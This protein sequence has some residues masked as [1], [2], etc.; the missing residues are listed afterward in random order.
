MYPL[1]RGSNSLIKSL[2]D[3]N[4]GPN[5]TKL[6]P[7]TKEIIPGT[8]NS[9]HVYAEL[10]GVVPNMMTARVEEAMHFFG[11]LLKHIGEDRI[12]WG[13]DCLWFASP[14]P[15]IEAFRC[16]EIS[17]KFQEKYGYPALTQERKS[18][19]FGQNSARLQTVRGIDTYVGK[20]HADI[21]GEMAMRHKRE[22][23]EE[24]GRRRDMIDRVWGPRTR[25]EFLAL[26][27]QEEREK[28]FWSG[29]IPHRS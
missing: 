17:T 3:A 24:F 4:I 19:I 8:E 7:K 1:D 16:F 20:C 25:R 13:T 29:R 28:Q 9:T 26:H 27:D 14:Q 15:I 2:R 10:G 12:L 6:D 22:L 21:V 23:D 11:K 18:K 5:G